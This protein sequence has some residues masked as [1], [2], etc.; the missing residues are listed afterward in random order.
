VASPAD[1]IRDKRTTPFNIGTRVELH[2]FSPAE[3]QAL[4]P[5]LAAAGPEGGALLRRVLYWT[6]GH[7]YL[8]QRLC[9]AVAADRSITGTA[10][11]DRCCADL[12]LSAHARERDDNLLFVRERLLSAGAGVSEVLEVVDRV[13]AGRRVEDDEQNPWVDLVRLS[14]ITSSRDGILRIRNRIYSRVFD[15][16]WV[17]AS[18]PGAERR[19]QRA[20]YRQGVWRA[21]LFAAVV[22]A[23]LAVLGMAALKQRDRAVRQEGLNAQLLYAAEMNLAQQAWAHGDARRVLQLLDKNVPRDGAADPRGFEWYY[24]WHATHAYR[25]SFTGHGAAVTAMDITADGRR[26][27]T[28][29][30][31][32]TARIWDVESGRCLTT[33]NGGDTNLVAVALSPDGTFVATGGPTLRLWNT[34]SGRQLAVLEGHEGRVASLAFAP[35]GRVLASA[36]W[37]LTI[38]LW[39]LASQRETRRL[40]AH[41]NRVTSIAFASDGHRL[42]SGAMDGTARVWDVATGRNEILVNQ[43]ENGVQ[44]VSF[45][46]DGSMV[47]VAGWLDGVEVWSVESKRLLRRLRGHNGMVSSTAF[48][49]DGLSLVSGGLDGVAR[50]WDVRSGAEK[51]KLS[52]NEGTSVSAVSFAPGGEFLTGGGNNAAELWDVGTGQNAQVLRAHQGPVSS[53]SFSPD[54]RMLA[55]GSWERVA[56]LWNLETNLPVMTMTHP[57]GRIQR[58]AFS[59]DGARLTVSGTEPSVEIW[60]A[61]TGRQTGVLATAFNPL[62]SADGTRVLARHPE[63]IYWAGG[64]EWLKEGPVKPD[65]EWGLGALSPDERWIVVGRHDGMMQIWD[66]NTLQVLKTWQAHAGAIA[67]VV[68]SPDGQLMAT[69]SLD[70]TI[71]LWRDFAEVAALSG[72]KGWVN[73]ISFS[74]DGR[75]LASAS[76]DETVKIWDV[77]HHHELMTLT[78]HAGSVMTVAFSPDGQLLASG[79]ADHTVRLWRAAAAGR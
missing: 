37:D 75:R 23:A 40:T 19:R 2:D 78:G 69:A 30:W 56:K 71:K 36:S 63:G 10:E 42:A 6:G 51:Q 67:A 8:T 17:Q 73:A 16:H 55:T 52:V 13:R 64:A 53:L 43:P 66:A 60:D 29:S 61:H 26:L 18:L 70:S 15:A 4:L 58:V 22:I 12:F 9:Q 65:G 45:S 3:A 33:L 27:V 39:D 76:F 44:S 31:D 54:G 21:S 20:A 11:V 79:G 49:R 38:R 48:S 46:P 7:P 32:G 35:D 72:H 25:G 47:A 5:G 50:V 34:E 68:F 1:L 41:T 74:P 59:A 28:A 62:F 57:V 24:L 77:A 14:G